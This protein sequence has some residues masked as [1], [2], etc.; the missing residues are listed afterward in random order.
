MA[1]EF[2]GHHSSP[3]AM[4]SNNLPIADVNDPECSSLVNTIRGHRTMTDSFLEFS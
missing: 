4:S 3:N 1:F 2:D